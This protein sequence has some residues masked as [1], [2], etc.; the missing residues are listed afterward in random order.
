MTFE[1]IAL[2]P[3]LHGEEVLTQAMVQALDKISSGVILQMAAH[4]HTAEQL[5]QACELIQDNQIA[6]LGPIKEG[7]VE[8]QQF[9]EQLQIP[10]GLSAECYYLLHF[11]ASP[12]QPFQEQNLIYD[13]PKTAGFNLTSHYQA[14][15]QQALQAASLKQKRI[16]TV[17]DE[18]ADSS[19]LLDAIEHVAAIEYPDLQVQF[20][21]IDEVSL[22]LASDSERYNFLITHRLFGKIIKNQLYGKSVAKRLCAKSYLGSNGALFYAVELANP[23]QLE[24]DPASLMLASVNLLEYLGKDNEAEAMLNALSQTISFDDRLTCAF[25]GHHSGNDFTQ[26]VL[27]RL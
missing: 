22:N 24:D 17:V 13:L 10:L 21:S 18:A 12:F 3:S 2:I 27:E 11:P 19:E 16:V 8:E 1:R 25:G 7:C 5:E 26:A 14:F 20:S 4:P 6:L 23:M 9:K 15:A